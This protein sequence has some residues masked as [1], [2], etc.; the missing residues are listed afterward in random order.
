[1]VGVLVFALYDHLFGPMAWA[2]DTDIFALM[3]QWIF[4][5]IGRQI[6]KVYPIYE[7]P[8]PMPWSAFIDEIERE[9]TPDELRQLENARAFYCEPIWDWPQFR[10]EKRPW[11]HEWDGL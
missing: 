9:A 6:H 2:A 4:H 8:E 11:D 5:P 1:M 3:E 10:L 7:D